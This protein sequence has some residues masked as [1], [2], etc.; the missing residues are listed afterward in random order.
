MDANWGLFR[1]DHPDTSKNA[2]HAVRSVTPKL[3]TLVHTW[4]IER[5]EAGATDEEIQEGLAISPN[6][7]R[8][9]RVELQRSG[10]V[11][12]SGKRRPTRSGRKAIVWVAKEV[13]AGRM[14]TRIR[15]TG[16]ALDARHQD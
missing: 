1:S 10:A 14:P 3:R 8:P 2:A 12:D 6:T 4:L 5:G 7:Q 9:R 13:D 11:T 15:G 16:E